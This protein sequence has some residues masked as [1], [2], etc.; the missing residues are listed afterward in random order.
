M[1][2]STSTPSAPA[3]P[4]KPR[5]RTGKST[6]AVKSPPSPPSSS[7][8]GSGSGPGAKPGSMSD[9]HKAALALGRDQGMAVRKYL[10]AVDAQAKSE[11]RGRRRTPESIKA[12]IA[13]VNRDILTADVVKRLTLIQRRLDLESDL[14]SMDAEIDLAAI[15]AGFV[16]SAGAYAARKALSYTAFRQLGVPAEV[17]KRAGI[18][19]A[20]SVR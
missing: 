19:R 11:R 9:S 16:A 3:S 1:A 7:S 8:N 18:M 6:A 15:E 12:Q 20:G 10:E 2:T 13:A 14:A 4:T 17:L 5:G